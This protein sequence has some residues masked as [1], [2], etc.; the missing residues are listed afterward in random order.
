MP[1]EQR[2]LVGDLALLAEGHNGKGAAAGGI[3]VHGEVF[4]VGLSGSAL[5]SLAAKWAH[6]GMARLRRIETD[7]DEV[8]IPGIAAN[9]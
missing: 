6:G 5:G 9:V 2:D 7:L 8:G 3:P 1:T 4:G